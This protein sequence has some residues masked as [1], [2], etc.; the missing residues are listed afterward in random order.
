MTG[1]QVDRTDPAARARLEAALLRRRRGAAA[2]GIRV[3]PRPAGE[4]RF[5]AAVTQEGMWRGLAG[6]SGPAPAILAAVR[7]Y[8]ALD[9]AAL[10]E[11]WNAVVARH[12]TLRS[13]LRVEAGVLTQ[14][15][16][17]ELRLPVE[18]TELTDPADFG[19]FVWKEG[20]RPF[21]LEHGPLARLKLLRLGADD[22]IVFLMVHHII[23][24]ART[25]EVVVRDLGACYV[26]ATAGVPAPL[27]PL[28]VQFADFAAW[29]RERLDGPRGAEL[30][31]YWVERLAGA[32]P[33]VLPA[34][35]ELP[36][37]PSQRGT[38]IDVPMPDELYAAIRRL[39]KER[40]TTLYTVGLAAFTALLARRSGQADICVRAPISF[41]DT[42]DVRDLV[43][44][45][46]NDVIVRTG[47]RDDPTLHELLERI[48]AG[49]AADFAHHDLPPHLLEPHLPDPGLLARLFH[50][51]FTAEEEFDTPDTL[52]DLRMEPV[53]PER[54]HVLR[55][56]NIRLRY[57]AERAHCIVLYR[58]EQFTAG[59]IEELM[60][61]Y[62]GLLAEMVRTPENRVFG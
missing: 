8:G 35:L 59:R 23:G 47:L 56:L 37:V 58:T 16:V 29:H 26:A 3:L 24:D 46:S 7:L 60:R 42:S 12:E 50:V 41:R 30:I 48:K 43:A 20:D 19:A 31:A 11:A 62:H 36:P 2:E 27:E 53:V 38:G 14:V 52:G 18:L 13:S 17:P 40:S 39:A 5:R 9:V 10:E 45:F 6:S 55:P 21:D 1:T 61:E 4:L 34:D 49:T 32:E 22:H 54:Q 28:R 51:Q 25:V 33:A 57:D 15:V 44:D